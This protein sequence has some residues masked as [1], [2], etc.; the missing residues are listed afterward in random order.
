MTTVQNRRPSIGR[1]ATGRPRPD[2]GDRSIRTASLTAGIGLFAMVILAVFAILVVLEGLVT[3]GDA[4]RT[5]E[6]I[7][8]SEGLFRS[9]VAS[10]AVVAVLDIVV[11]AALFH[12][13]APVDRVAS[14]FAAWLRLAYAVVLLVAIGMLAGVLPL[15][16]DPDQV[17][18]GI[19]AFYD[20]YNA[21]LI[22][23][24]VHLM[25]I[26]YLAYRSA[27]VPRV[28]GVV[29]LVAGAGYLIDR[30]GTLLL[31]DYSL[32]IAAF[33]GPGEIALAFWLLVK[34]VRS[35]APADPHSPVDRVAA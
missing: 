21:G 3:P 14:M 6:A 10:L 33:T 20:V 1:R 7:A 5:M 16:D 25:V 19:A 23:F 27:T 32:E 35:P 30:F 17:M 4:V 8:A 9:G 2:V 24:G 34:G 13:F 26:G 28:I 29:L 15:S 31:A 18:Q 11:A 22:L 12:L